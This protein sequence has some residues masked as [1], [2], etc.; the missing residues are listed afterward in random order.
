MTSSRTKAAQPKTS[1]PIAKVL[2][3]PEAAL[4]CA[5]ERSAWLKPRVGL[6]SMSMN[7]SGMCFRH[8]LFAPIVARTDL[9]RLGQACHID[10]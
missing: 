2:L 9:F 10:S 4:I 1:T 6:A 7:S 5:F 8:F 3:L